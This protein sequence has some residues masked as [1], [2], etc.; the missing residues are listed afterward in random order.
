LQVEV[1]VLAHKR[2]VDELAD[3]LGLCVGALA[4][5]EIVGRAFDEEGEGVG[6]VVAGVAGR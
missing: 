4:E 1:R 6:G 3:A 2:I 5:V